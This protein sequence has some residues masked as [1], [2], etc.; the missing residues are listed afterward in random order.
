[1]SYRV[2]VHIKLSAET[3]EV[4]MGAALVATVS[5]AIAYLINA[6]SPSIH[7]AGLMSMLPRDLEKVTPLLTECRLRGYAPDDIYCA[8]IMADV[9][10]DFARNR[11]LVLNED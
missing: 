5:G 9:G 7:Y 2:Y 8:G 10:D 3:M 11:H 1:M 4:F 6:H